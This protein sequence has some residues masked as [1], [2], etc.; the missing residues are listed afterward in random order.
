ME[1]QVA[2]NI[3]QMLLNSTVNSE[4]KILSIVTEPKPRGF[5]NFTQDKTN[6]STF[7]IQ[8]LVTGSTYYFMFADWNHRISP[9][10][11]YIVVFDETRQN[12]ILEMQE[13]SAGCLSWK[14]M[15]R[16]QKTSE[17]N[18]ERKIQFQQYY[19]SDMVGIELPATEVDIP[20]FLADIFALIQN[21]IRCV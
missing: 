13:V 3:I 15:P 12:T 21:R 16:K 18:H 1:L 17:F 7:Q 20:D 11:F 19:G 2:E 6:L 8:E 4:Y 14:Y 10:E 9:P 5:V